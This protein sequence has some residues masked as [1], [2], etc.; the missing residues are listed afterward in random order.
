MSVSDVEADSI[1]FYVRDKLRLETQSA[2]SDA[3][4]AQAATRVL[5]TG[6]NIAFD[7]AFSLPDTYH[8]C[9]NHYV[10]KMG[11]AGSCS[12]CRSSVAVWQGVYVYLEFSIT[13]QSEQNPSSFVSGPVDLS[14]GLIPA[15]CPPNVSAG[16]W[17][18]SVGLLSDGKLLVAGKQCHSESVDTLSSS[19]VQVSAST[20]I[21]MLIY[22]PKNSHAPPNINHR[23]SSTRTSPQYWSK[24]PPV[25][26]RQTIPT[27]HENDDIDTLCF[28]ENESEYNI[29]QWENPDHHDA[30]C[31][32]DTEIEKTLPLSWNKDSD[33]KEQFCIT[34]NLN[35]RV[36][37][38]SAAT[39]TL[40][41]DSFD[42]ERDSSPQLYAVVSLMSK[43]SGSWCRF[44]E[45]DVVYKTRK[46][47]GAPAGERIY[48][49]D[50]SL[51][52]ESNS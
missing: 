41:A 49:M 30:S 4:S 29:T 3:L 43:N 1:V 26:E 14:I 16:Q 19:S 34:Y 6:R 46:E 20:T 24:C 48:C 21:G 33:K 23:M 13:S 9:G 25:P 18:Q 10:L 32:T 47:I 11:S 45:S 17:P 5:K 7:P 2:S 39:R 31:L 12:S 28:Q 42:M 37:G 38:M 52:L 50:G 22:I 51:L 35:G 27:D 8:A 36:V 40:I 44:S 15:D